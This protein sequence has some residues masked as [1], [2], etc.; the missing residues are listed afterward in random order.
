M[1]RL[2]LLLSLIAVP[3]LV[4][5]GV[6]W[7]RNQSLPV[8]LARAKVQ[9]GKPQAGVLL[10]QLAR[11]YPDS[12]ELQFVLGRHLALQEKWEPAL[13]SFKR[14]GDL[15]YNREQV[16]RETLFVRAQLDFD[17]ALPQLQ[18]LLD[19]D[20]NDRDA[21]IALARG[22]AKRRFHTQA[23]ALTSTVL[24]RNPQDG[25]VLYLRGVIRFQARR[26]DQAKADLEQALHLDPDSFYAQRA[27]L[28]LGSV[29]LD[30]GQFAEAMRTFRKCQAEEPANLVALYGVG[31][32]ASFLSGTTGDRGRQN[33]LFDEAL[34]A[35]FEV[36]RLRPGNVETILKVVNIY[37]KRGDFEAMLEWL[38]KAEE[39]DRDRF[40]T[41][42]AKAR[43]LRAVGQTAQAEVYQK[44]YD[45]V[46]K[47]RWV[48]R[49]GALGAGDDRNAPTPPRNP[50][51]NGP[52]DDLPP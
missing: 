52:A 50:T 39:Q 9:L 7:Q 42:F 8:Q 43:A 2:V 17:A 49:E 21:R 10:E 41:L 4:G 47:L 46:T 51:E 36:L 30:L 45:E 3:A 31:Q 19:A 15:G 34:E 13:N 11:Q 25:F 40:E 23:D 28:V 48:R 32:A 6:Y 35:F 5:A 24:A 29:Q 14:A 27:R 33:E 44:R 1:K 12:A 18:I 37:E 26:L 20:P 16:E 22:Y 38:D